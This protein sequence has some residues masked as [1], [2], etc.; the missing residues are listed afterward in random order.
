M[1]MALKLSFISSGER[2]FFS[3]EQIIRLE[4]VSNYTNVY[5]VGHR[6]I[7]MA[8]LLGEYEAMLRPYG[9]VR[10]HRSH[11]V[12]TQHIL[13]A[14]ERQGIIMNDES[15]PEVSRRK[16]KQVMSELRREVAAIG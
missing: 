13:R 12:N 2:C 10:T 14:N 8:K 7:M 9:F 4:A 3:P 6:P 1:K 16:K 15:R 5:F 11:L